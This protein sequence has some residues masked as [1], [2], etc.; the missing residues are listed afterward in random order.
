MSTLELTV[1]YYQDS[2]ANGLSWREEHFVRR[3]VDMQL[4]VE[5]TAL[6]LVDTWDNHF[7]ESW[8][9]RAE[10]MTREAVVP[11]L[12]AGREA[13]L[14]VVHAPSPNVAKHF[15]EHLQRHQAAAPGVPSDWP[16]SEFRS[17]QGEYAAFRGPRAQP[18]GIPSIEI[19]MSPHIDVRDDDVLLATGL[20]LHDLCRE[21]GI[22][23]LIYA[24][25][26]TNWC[27][28]NRDYGMRSMARYGYN[29]ILLREATMGVEYP[30]T[31]DECFATEL[32]IR[33][34][35]TQL[36]FSASN[37]HYLT[38]CNAARR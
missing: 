10:F 31:V 36:G 11:V 1:Q 37:A 33:E 14:T 8:L 20:Q 5:Q 17:R 30:D 13:G 9:E 35:E 21:R 26:A 2:P 7:I 23:H 38:A 34:V 28:L 24:G 22:L 15:P 25:F 3:T 18:P 16:P 27:I 29:L 19:G 6:V 12:N 32:A 4:P